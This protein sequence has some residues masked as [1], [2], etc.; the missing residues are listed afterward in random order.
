MATSFSPVTEDFTC[1]L[2]PP[3][4]L[5][6]DISS[7]ETVAISINA[8]VRRRSELCRGIGYSPWRAKFISKADALYEKRTAVSNRSQVNWY[9]NSF[10]GNSF[11]PDV[12]RC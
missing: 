2:F 3:P 8:K 11:E 9:I 1:R 5:H 10:D 6:P 7:R 4:L 12:L